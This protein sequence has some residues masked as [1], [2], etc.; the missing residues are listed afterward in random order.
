MRYQ[1]ALICFGLVAMFFSQAPVVYADPPPWAP[2]HGWRTKHDPYYVGYAGRQWPNDYGISS[3]RCN[4]D[5]VGTAL[6]G[7]VGG[8]IG[9]TVGKG[10]GRAVAIILGTVIGAVIGNKIG[11]DL[12]N[13][14][15]GCLGHT[16]ELGAQNKPVTWNNAANG[17][18]YTV[19]PLDGFSANGQKCRNYRL[20]LRG[21]GIHDTSSQRA[22]LSE[23]GTW[24]PY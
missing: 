4:R 20:N 14:D 24:K 22:C 2:A 7:I 15:R 5:A 18:N 1:K 16:L 10:D 11:R 12:D 21:N 8:A 9:S 17:L 3:G 13:A 6:G 19:T 23:D